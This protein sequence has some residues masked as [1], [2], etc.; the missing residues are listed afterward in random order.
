M[1]PIFDQFNN[2][3]SSVVGAAIRIPLLN[4]FRAKKVVALK[5]RY[6][7]LQDRRLSKSPCG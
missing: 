3:L 7:I 5:R 2:N 6:L 1:M 4:G